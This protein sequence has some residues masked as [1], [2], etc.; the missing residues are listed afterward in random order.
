MR[1][2]FFQS[3][4]QGVETV[5][6]KHVHF[7]NQVD[8]VTSTGRSILD[9]VHQITGFIHLGPGCSIHLD[10]IHEPALIDTDAGRT[11]SARSGTYSLFA[12]Q[13]LGQY[14]RDG[15]LTDPAGAGK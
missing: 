5:I 3:F 7:V 6:G 4:Q 14:A 11:F 9:V 2:W 13:A 1:R 15:C 8:L 10:Q 12:I